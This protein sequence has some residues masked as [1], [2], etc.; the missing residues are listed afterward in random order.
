MRRFVAHDGPYWWWVAIHDTTAD[1]I[2]A[3]DRLGRR[4]GDHDPQPDGTLACFQPANFIYW[5]PADAD[6]PRELRRRNGYVGTM[7]LTADADTEVVVHECVH[8][9]LRIYRVEHDEQAA[10]GDNCGEP[11]ENLAYIIGRTARTMATALHD[12][13]IWS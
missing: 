13:G 7:R 2:A 8:L 3:A 6:E 11:E 5:V 9:A 10:I 12:R 4:R 1:L